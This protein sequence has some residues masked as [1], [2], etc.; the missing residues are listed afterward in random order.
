MGDSA[1]AQEAEACVAAVL[2]AMR[3]PG[4]RAVCA[5]ATLSDDAGLLFLE[6]P[7]AALRTV[8]KLLPLTADRPPAQ[9]F[10][11]LITRA[12]AV[13][14]SD[15]HVVRC[16]RRHALSWLCHRETP[17][18]AVT[19]TACAVSPPVVFE[20]PT[21]LLTHLLTGTGRESWHA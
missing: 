5:D 21:L 16:R 11:P 8:A 7:L 17:S 2:E 10:K 19:A 13:A 12:R 14:T 18:L 9:R 1:E 3:E 20:P 4:F 15:A 6:C